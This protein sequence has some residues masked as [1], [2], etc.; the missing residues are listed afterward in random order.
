[1]KSTNIKNKGIPLFL[2]CSFRKED[3][4]IRNFFEGL[5]FANGFDVY[6]MAHPTIKNP[7]DKALKEIESRPA[8]A[9][10]LTKRGAIKNKAFNIPPWLVAESTIAYFKKHKKLTMIFVEEGLSEQEIGPVKSLIGLSN[11]PK[12][13]RNNIENYIVGISKYIKEAKEEYYD[14]PLQYTL[15]YEPRY[16]FTIISDYNKIDISRN[17]AGLM[18]HSFKININSKN[19]EQVKHFLF[20]SKEQK[21]N[22][23]PIKQMINNYIKNKKE[24]SWFSYNILS[25]YSTKKPINIDVNE[26]KKESTHRK[27]IFLI[28]FEGLDSY[29]SPLEYGWSWHQPNFFRVKGND[30]YEYQLNYD[31]SSLAM[32]VEFEIP[33]NLKKNLFIDMPKLTTLDPSRNK[34]GVSEE[35]QPRKTNRSIQYKWV[36]SGK[37]GLIYNISWKK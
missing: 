8:F 4:R 23:P 17:G 14:K 30:S 24:L 22:I 5:F 3:T 6:V 33:P 19:F 11:P 18:G 7:L 26:L 25:T 27:C 37:A 34:I 9:V 12:F 21:G 29:P 10:I 31:I 35:A 15:S 32:E 16:H 20:L 36:K 28:S 2:S 1:M 13:N